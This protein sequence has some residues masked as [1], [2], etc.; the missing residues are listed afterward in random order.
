VSAKLDSNWNAKCVR[1]VPLCRQMPLME[2]L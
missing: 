2:A 1:H